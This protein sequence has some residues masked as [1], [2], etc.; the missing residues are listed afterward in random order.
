MSHDDEIERITEIERIGSGRPSYLEMDTA[1][2]ARMH[3]ALAAG[4]EC[5]P[6][7]SN[8]NREVSSGQPSGDQGRSQI[9]IFE[10]VPFQVGLSRR[11]PVRSSNLGVAAPSASKAPKDKGPAQ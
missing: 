9:A 3:A 6:T 1:F 7:K 5:A 11:K 4:L 8:K 10:E 2:C